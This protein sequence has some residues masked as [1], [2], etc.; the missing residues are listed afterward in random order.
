[1]IDFWQAMSP[2]INLTQFTYLRAFE[3]IFN[4]DGLPDE[5]EKLP[6]I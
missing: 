4:S 3:E 1:M 2:L 5:P 6:R